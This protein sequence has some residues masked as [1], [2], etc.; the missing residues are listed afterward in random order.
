MSRMTITLDEELIETAMEELGATTKSEAIRMAL[1]EVVRRKRLKQALE[2][3]GQIALDLDQD[4][5]RE[6][7]AAS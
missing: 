5:L 1:A 3:G 7:R 2:H 6:L 4:A